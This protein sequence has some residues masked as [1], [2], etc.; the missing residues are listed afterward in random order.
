MAEVNKEQEL[1]TK[2]NF[3]DKDLKQ[4]TDAGLTID[5]IYSI[6]FAPDADTSK[7]IQKELS[8]DNK[9]ITTALKQV[10][11]NIKWVS[12]DMRKTAETIDNSSADTQPPAVGGSAK[13]KEINEK[14]REYD[15][16]QQ[17]NDKE[18]AENAEGDAQDKKDRDNAGYTQKDIEIIKEFL[19]NYKPQAITQADSKE[20][21]DALN[22]LMNI[23]KDADE[24]E[25]NNVTAMLEEEGNNLD[26]T[27]PEGQKDA[28]DYINTYSSIINNSDA[29][30]KMM[31]IN[32]RNQILTALS[33]GISAAFG[34]PA[35]DFTDSADLKEAQEQV[36]E[37]H[38]YLNDQKNKQR[39]VENKKRETFIENE[40]KQ[41][42]NK[43]IAA[44]Q[45]ADDAVTHY[46]LAKTN[47]ILNQANLNSSLDKMKMTID[48]GTVKD[49]TGKDI[50]ANSIIG[51]EMNRLG[52]KAWGSYLRSG[53]GGIIEEAPKTAMN[54]VSKVSDERAKKFFTNIDMFR[55]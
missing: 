37:V 19:S 43:K 28:E 25:F 16:A 42:D 29:Y 45:K 10:Q 51:Q 4:L 1:R 20:R 50:S 34:V 12:D 54:V 47:D 22:E 2:Y 27:T 53:I 40:K 18:G 26:I 15:K 39:E 44:K 48:L 33:G 49:K 21:D 6:Y 35:M 8:K 30:K 7:N 55:R 23:S 9:K 41:A 5:Q 17:N 11:K 14:G 52:D 38:S 3:G 32:R 36:K 46:N 31:G 24:E 13:D